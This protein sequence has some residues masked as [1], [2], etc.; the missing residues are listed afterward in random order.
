VKYVLMIYSNPVTWEH[1]MFLHQ[2][3]PLSAEER[4][5]RLTQFV[6]LYKEI[7][8]SGELV[9]ARALADPINTKTVRVR[10]ETMTTTDGPFLESKEHL[11]GFFIVDCDSV[12]RATEI[13]GRFPDARH[14]AVEVRPI[15][16][17]SG[18]E[19]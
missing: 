13:A 9:D 8:E 1:P 14:F 19:M 18:P 12:E 17:M 11:A 15:M 16:D 10:D 4:D 6:E 3:E 7:L 5:A 2:G